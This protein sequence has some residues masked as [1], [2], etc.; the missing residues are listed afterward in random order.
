MDRVD[1]LDVLANRARLLSLCNRALNIL[2]F[3]KNT[4]LCGMRFSHCVVAENKQLLTNIHDFLMCR[5]FQ[6][7]DDLHHVYVLVWHEHKPQQPKITCVAH[8]YHQYTQLVRDVL[9]FSLSVG[10]RILC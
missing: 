3:P 8:L 7:D 6:T 5:L 4:F 9:H 1:M 2:L 10:K